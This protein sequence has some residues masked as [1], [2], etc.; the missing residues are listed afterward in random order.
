MLLEHLGQL[1][2]A[3]DLPIFDLFGSRDAENLVWLRSPFAEDRRVLLLKS[4][5]V[6]VSSSWNVKN[7]CDFQLAD[8]ETNDIIISSFPLYHD[9]GDMLFNS[10]EIT[11]AFEYRG[12]HGWKKLVFVI[13]RESSNLFYSRLKI[14]QDANLAKGMMIG[15]IREMR[16][17]GFSLGMDTLRSLGV[18]K[19]L[20]DMAN[21]TI[22][23]CIGSSSI[24]REYNY[25]FKH[26]KPWTLRKAKPDRFLILS[27]RGSIG[28][29]SF[30]AHSW[31]KEPRENLLNHLGIRVERGEIPE[32]ARSLGTK[33]STLS[34]QDHAD[35]IAAYVEGDMGQRRLADKLGYSS[36]TVNGHIRYHNK[37]V[38]RSGW[39]SRCKSVKSRYTDV[40]AEKT[41]EKG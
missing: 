21:Y 11:K 35:L 6:D 31:H 38:K 12:A 22:F 8:L 17:M 39:C 9:T 14:D 5:H 33:G 19:D 28:R 15:L 26:V 36:A 32:E 7:A 41:K 18:D 25:I 30:P 2:L 27:D 13:V 3:A 29:G 23:K 20:R 40:L 16:H 34:S 10:G 37:A 1:H 24:P 4:K